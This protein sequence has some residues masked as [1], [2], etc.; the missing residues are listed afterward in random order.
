MNKEQRHAL[1]AAA[2]LGDRSAARELEEMQENTLWAI[3][4]ICGTIVVVVATVCL[5]HGCDVDSVNT[6]RS[7]QRRQELRLKYIEQCKMTPDEVIKV[8]SDVKKH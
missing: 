4:T 2:L 5:T 1:R 3:L 8:T 6:E 7:N